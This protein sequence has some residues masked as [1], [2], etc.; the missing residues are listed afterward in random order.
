MLKNYS[1]NILKIWLRAV[2]SKI[3]LI[4]IYVVNVKFSKII[5]Y[6]YGCDVASI[7]QPKLCQ[8]VLNI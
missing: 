4:Y 8:L 5:I 2:T 3:Y 7:K 6:Y 1:F